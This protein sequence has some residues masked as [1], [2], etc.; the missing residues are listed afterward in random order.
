MKKT[1]EIYLIYTGFGIA[2]YILAGLPVFDAVNLAFTSIS[3]GGM[4]IKNL[5]VG[6]YQNNIIYV[7]TMFLMIL[8]AISFNVHYKVIKTKGNPFL[9]I[10]SSESWLHSSYSSQS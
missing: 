3:T 4:S 8:G 10:S 1:L 9:K 5:N 2:L 6:F 7:I